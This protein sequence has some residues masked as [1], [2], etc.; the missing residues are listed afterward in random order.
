VAI[1]GVPAAPAAPRAGF[2]ADVLEH[3]AF[4]KLHVEASRALAVRRRRAPVVRANAATGLGSLGAGARHT[5]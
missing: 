3:R 1:D 4:A 5:R 2:E